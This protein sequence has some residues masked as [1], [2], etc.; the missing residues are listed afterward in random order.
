MNFSD[1]EKIVFPISEKFKTRTSQWS[2]D[3]VFYDKENII[4]HQNF[5]Y[6]IDGI[7]HLQKV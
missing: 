4:L 2:K 7:C 6:K 5:R 3:M 1:Q